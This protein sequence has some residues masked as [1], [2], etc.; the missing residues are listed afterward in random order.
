MLI[1]IYTYVILY[2][3]DLII[4]TKDNNTMNNFKKFLMKQFDMVDLHNINYFL[5][6]RINRS[7]SEISLDQTT[8]LKSVLQKFNM[9][10]CNPIST[11]L[12]V[13]LNYSALNSEDSYD[14]PCRNVIGCLMYAMLCTRPDLCT[15]V[16]LL[17]RYQTKCNK[18]LWLCLKRVLRYIKGTI[19][20]KLVYRRI[21]NNYKEIL[22]GYVDADWAN[23]EVDRRSTTGCLFKLYDN[24]TVTWITRRQN[25]VA[26]SSTEAEYM[27][28]FEAVKEALG[29][30]SLLLSIN[31]NMFKPIILYEDN[32]S[33][34]AMSNNPVNHKRSKHIDIKYHFTREQVENKMIC[35][36]YWPTGQQEADLL[37]KSLPSPQFKDLKKRMGLEEK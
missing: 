29:L 9:S 19:N 6:I 25:S 8:Y 3:D 20:I 31:V 2:V 18:E 7:S 15:A 16:N 11:P 1:K 37:T 32:Q 14:A 4:A 10:N 21:D 27:A 23:N 30:R 36:R 26:T 28:V 24:C 17:S 22:T 13:K 5:G 12:P 33:C 35:L 34:I